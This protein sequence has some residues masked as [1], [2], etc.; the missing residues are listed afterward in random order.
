MITNQ[1]HI[2]IRIYQT[3]QIFATIISYLLQHLFF[4]KIFLSLFGQFISIDICAYK[5]ERL[6]Q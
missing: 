4:I 2:F 1:E 5:K 3:F 6:P